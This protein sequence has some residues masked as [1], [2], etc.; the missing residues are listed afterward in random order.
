MLVQEAGRLFHPAKSLPDLQPRA[1]DRDDDL[2]G[3]SSKFL[4]ELALHGGL[5]PYGHAAQLCNNWGNCDVRCRSH[6]RRDPPHEYQLHLHLL[7]D[8]KAG[9]QRGLP[10]P[11]KGVGEQVEHDFCVV[12][13]RLGKSGHLLHA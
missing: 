6:T 12:R 7:H 1:G 13:N 2:V 11:L 9:V 8:S 10:E 5:L 3:A 4:A